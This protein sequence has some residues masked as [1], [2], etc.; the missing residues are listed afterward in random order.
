M[1]QLDRRKFLKGSAA[2]AAATGA[3]TLA[4]GAAPTPLA[5]PSK[6]GPGGDYQWQVL[7]ADDAAIL[8]AA[9]DRIIPE[10]ELS[11]AASALGIPEFIDRQLAGLSA[12]ARGGTCK[13]RFPTASPARAISHADRRP[14]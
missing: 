14:N 10:D 5:A 11:P 9:A 8:A 6:I 2:V 4:R 1:T 7:N 3:A 13:A 12:A